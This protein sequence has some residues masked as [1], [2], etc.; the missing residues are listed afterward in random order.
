MFKEM[1][2]KEMILTDGGAIGTGIVALCYY[3]GKAAGVAIAK[4]GVK[5]TM[6]KGAKWAAAGTAGYALNETLDWIRG[7]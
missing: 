6:V 5:A 4:A 2:H 1:T 7:E 3:G